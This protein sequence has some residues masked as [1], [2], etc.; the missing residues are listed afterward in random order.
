[1]RGR[2]VIEQMRAAL[3]VEGFGYLKVVKPLG[4]NIERCLA[5]RTLTVHAPFGR[6]GGQYGG[7]SYALRDITT[8]GAVPFTDGA[9]NPPIPFA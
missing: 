1:M 3:V 9:D 2:R 8:H 7:L 5:M 6:L 4:G